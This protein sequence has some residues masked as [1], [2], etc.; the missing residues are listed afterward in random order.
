MSSEKTNLGKMQGTPWH[1]GFVQK[2]ENDP[3]RHKSHCIHHQTDGS[4]SIYARCIGSSHCSFYVDAL[5]KKKRAAY[6]ESKKHVM[7]AVPEHSLKSLVQLGDTVTIYCVE[8]GISYSVE[9]PQK[10]RNLN[11]L[12]EIQRSCLG[13]SLNAEFSCAGFQYLI[14]KIHKH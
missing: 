2:K 13:R 9:L 3:R 12:S 1:V 14:R 5:L 4:C 8:E 7:E 6:K 10:L 11:E